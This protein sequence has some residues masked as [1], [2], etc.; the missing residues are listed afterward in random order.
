MESKSDRIIAEPWS[1]GKLGKVDISLKLYWFVKG[2]SS[3]NSWL[4]FEMAKYQFGDKV[5]G[6]SEIS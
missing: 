3:I 4:F 2:Y 1:F 6:D 5:I